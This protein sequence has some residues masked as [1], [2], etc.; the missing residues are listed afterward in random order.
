MW[1]LILWVVSEVFVGNRRGEEVRP[2]S[3]RE[4]G[5][6]HAAPTHPIERVGAIGVAGR[7][8]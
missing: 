3:G 4:A 6:G 7:D 8:G 1:G 2:Q 5:L